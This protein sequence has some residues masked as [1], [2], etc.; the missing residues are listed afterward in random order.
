MEEYLKMGK[1]SVKKGTLSEEKV[2]EN[3]FHLTYWF[4]SLT[5][6]SRDLYHKACKEGENTCRV[7]HISL[8]YFMKT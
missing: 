1:E 6:L 7:L 5:G 8:G 2:F 4:I 3:S